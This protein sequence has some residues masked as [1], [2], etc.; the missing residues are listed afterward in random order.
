MVQCR[1]D[2]PRDLASYKSRCQIEAASSELGSLLIM[3]GIK[4]YPEYIM[5]GTCV[6]ENRGGCKLPL[7]W[8][9]DNVV[10]LCRTRKR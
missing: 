4:G 1:E 8:N 9:S 6:L 7:N 10:F 2:V 3:T 5:G